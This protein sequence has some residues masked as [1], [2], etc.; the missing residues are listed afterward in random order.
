MKAREEFKPFDVTEYLGTA[1]DRAAYLRAMWDDGAGDPTIVVTALGD[2]ARA[3]GMSQIARE[4]GVAREALYKALSPRGNPELGT[5]VKVLRALGLELSVQPKVSSAPTDASH[6]R[7]AAIFGEKPG[8][9]SRVITRS[10]SYAIEASPK[11]ARATVAS[12]LAQASNSKRA[13]SERA[14]V[15]SKSATARKRK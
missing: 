10:G 5:V 15:V 8:G 1:E 2:V 6:R 12:R 14:R 13:A 11:I 9:A 7:I 4:T 3:L